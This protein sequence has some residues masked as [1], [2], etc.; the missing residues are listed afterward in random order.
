[1]LN[2][3][4]YHEDD[5]APAATPAPANAEP[6]VAPASADALRKDTE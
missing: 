3:E 4:D 2:W 6:A 1:M 5:T